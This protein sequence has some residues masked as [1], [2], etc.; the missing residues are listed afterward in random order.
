MDAMRDW[1]P[2][3]C[4]EGHPIPR[5]DPLR[6][7]LSR[8]PTLPVAE[9]CGMMNGQIEDSPDLLAPGPS[10]FTTLPHLRPRNVGAR[11]SAT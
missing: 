5:T 6:G 9:V 1:T 2:A 3:M 8:R 10:A 4:A 7:G 11:R